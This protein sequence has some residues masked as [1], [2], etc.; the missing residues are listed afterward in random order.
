MS[1]RTSIWGVLCFLLVTVPALYFSLEGT[2][3][4][5]SEQPKFQQLK[6]DRSLAVLQAVIARDNRVHIDVRPVKRALLK[7]GIQSD[8]EI[9]LK[10]KGISLVS[11]RR[12]RDSVQ[13][14]KS[15]IRIPDKPLSCSLI[16]SIDV[17]IL[18]T[19]PVT[20]VFSDSAEYGGELKISH[21]IVHFVE[22]GSSQRL[23]FDFHIQNTGN[24]ICGHSNSGSVNHVHVHNYTFS[25][26]YGDYV[27]GNDQFNMVRMGPF[28]ETNI[29][30]PNNHLPG[31]ENLGPGD[32]YVL[33]LLTTQ[34]YCSK[35]TCRPKGADGV[36]AADIR[37]RESPG[38]EFKISPIKEKRFNFGVE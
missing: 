6:A 23:A 33:R 2:A 32:Y 9:Q 24:G 22:A 20:L 14:P 5:N 16:F 15:A 18:T 1:K 34:G 28:T 11:F 38:G 30:Y 35:S 7:A 29:D 36:I 26:I 21:I 3:W 25:T 37:Y 31:I 8:P 17:T 12:T 19:I 4:A 13:F 10:S 27:F